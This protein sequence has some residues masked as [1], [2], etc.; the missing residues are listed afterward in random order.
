MRMRWCWRSCWHCC[1]GWVCWV[2]FWWN[3]Y[4][5]YY[6][7]AYL[8][9]LRAHCSHL[10]KMKKRGSTGKAVSWD[11]NFGNFSCRR[12]GSL[13]LLYY[14][15][16]RSHPWKRTCHQKTSH[17]PRQNLCLLSAACASFDGFGTKLLPAKF[18]F[19]YNLNWHVLHEIFINFGNIVEKFHIVPNFSEVIPGVLTSP[20]KLQSLF[21]AVDKGTC[22]N[23]ILS[24]VP[25]VGYLCTL[26]GVF[27]AFHY[28]QIKTY[29][30]KTL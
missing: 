19:I 16:Y 14:C 21:V 2:K 1:S 10:R 6:W 25:T 3:C 7:E 20:R 29:S 24:R 5:Y 28:L 27:G 17:L 23:E 22:W 15:R 18:H 13:M 12:R 26:F 30:V 11:H 9:L 4:C 8:H